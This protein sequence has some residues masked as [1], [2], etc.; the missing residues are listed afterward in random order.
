MGSRDGGG[1]A[2]NDSITTH[3]TDDTHSSTMLDNKEKS[4]NSSTVDEEVQDDAETASIAESIGNQRK[5]LSKKQLLIAFPALATCLYVSF[6]DQTSVSTCIPAISAELN[7]G[8]STAWIGSS[9]LIASVAFQLINGR[10]S[11]IFGR[12][13]VLLASLLL[14]GLGDL[15]TGFAKTATQLFA[16]RAIAGIGGG[17]IN[18]IVMIIVSDVTTLA[19]RGKYQ[20]DSAPPCL[21]STGIL[22]SM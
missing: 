3:A 12:K 19:N 1:V 20:G 2:P 18:S 11:D 8:P 10:L 16:F 21:K 14:M 9:F 17:G 5:L 6:F 7:T 22:K 13:H 4:S 15:L